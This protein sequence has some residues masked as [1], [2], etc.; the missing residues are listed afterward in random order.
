MEK[1]EKR[2]EKIKNWFKNPYNLALFSIIILTIVIRLYY[3]FIVN[4]QPIWW[5]EAEFLNLAK[6]WAS[7]IEHL[8]Y[9]AVRPVLFSLIA[10][11]F[12][13][14][15]PTE[16]LPR[17]FMLILSVISVIGV[18]Y[19]G[20]ELYNERIGLLSSFFT[21][22]FYLNLFFT[23]RLQMDIPSL[24]FL[25]F[26]TL[27][28]YR[29]F[30]YNSNKDLYIGAALISIGTL[31]KQSAV[32]VLLAFFIYFLTTEKLKFLK[33]KEVWIAGLVFTL[34]QLPYIIWGYVRF[35]G[36]VYTRASSIFAPYPGTN[37]YLTSGYIV[38]KNYIMSFPNYLPWPLLI[39]FILGLLSMYKLILGFDILIKN[40]DKN[41]NKDWFIFLIFLIPF[42]ITSILITHNE[43][44]YLI[45]TFPIIFIISSVFIMTVYD[46]IKKHNKIVAIIL[47]VVLLG[48]NINFQIFS[49]GHADD[50]IKGKMYSYLEIKNAGLWLKA[51]TEPTDMVATQ[52]IHQIEYYSDRK[53]KVFSQNTT[54]FETL[55]Q[56]NP[57]LKYYVVSMVQNSPPWTYTYPQ[58]NNLTLVE[59]YFADVQQTQPL[60]I[61]YKM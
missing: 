44:R 25:V 37:N 27:F 4:N 15:S 6:H 51:N 46:F 8:R 17:A 10:A 29:Y 13:K 50:L 22:V 57:N 55:K 42:L 31:F 5:D 24:A 14:I 48:F 3:F 34:I 18:Y 23:F 45:H 19:L 32:F 58:E 52:S 2:A 21:S 33:K 11:L 56:E 59:V 53:T 7:G 16:F 60:L 40:K 26:G 43:N 35:S 61:I 36:F 9:D 38:F 49:A 47:L 28:F 54:D 30:K 39:I 12:F 41:L 1:I 20:K